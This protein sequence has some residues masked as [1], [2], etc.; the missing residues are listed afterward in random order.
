MKARIIFVLA[1]LACFSV[2]KASVSLIMPYK[3][4]NNGTQITVPV[5]VKDFINIVSTQ[6]TIQFD[7]AVISYVST[8]DY[9][10]PGM[11]SSNF[12]T[13]NIG[14]GQLTFMW[15][16]G[17]VNPNTLADSTVIFSITFNIIG[18][19]GQYS[20]L[21]FTNTPT[22]IEII[23]SSMGTETV[24]TVSGRVTVAG[25]PPLYD[26][27]L[28]YDT[29]SGTAGTNVNV[30]LRALDFT[31]VN[32]IQGT[33]LFDPAVVTY[34][35]VSFYGLPGMNSTNFG[36][37]LISSGKLTFSWMDGTLL[38][39]NMADNAAL[40]T[41]SFNLSGPQGSISPLKFAS[42]P[43]SWEVSDSLNNVLSAD[44][45]D[46]YIHINTITGIDVKDQAATTQLYQNSPNP[47]T[48]Q[49]QICFSLSEAGP[50]FISIFDLTGR[51]VFGFSGTFKKGA[52]SISWNGT[53]RDGKVLPEGMYF[54]RLQAGQT[55]ITKKMTIMQ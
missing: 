9:G 3:S 33:V 47:F 35:S 2:S 32:S 34:N 50:A 28:Y 23:N 4:G 19:S 16:D 15:F 24:L 11:N 51:D 30:S 27:T 55:V 48:T 12:G 1:L 29:I 10:L 49:T 7:P 18:S 43:T 54:Y 25:G 5:K 41:I 17:S 31:N 38:G 46:G 6:G 37:T 13:L 36:T 52:N 26:L 20:D 21:T 45:I 14:I 42:A 40:F 22:L 44:T 39:I 53:D 8:Q